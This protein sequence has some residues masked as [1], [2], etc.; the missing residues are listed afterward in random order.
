M[1]RVR[2][3][4]RVRQIVAVAMRYGFQQAVQE[5]ESAQKGL[6][7]RF[8]REEATPDPALA[9]MASGERL[10]RMLEALGPTFI[11]LGQL[12]S[13][14]PDLVPRWAVDELVKLQDRVAPMPLEVVRA[15]LEAELG[16]PPERLFRSF[17]PEPLGTASLGQVHRA[18]LPSGEVVA[19]KV[20]RPGIEKVVQRDLS[21]LAD[22]AE[23][24]EGRLGMTRHIKLTKVVAEL[25]QAL[26]DELVYTIEGR[27]AERMMQIVTPDDRVR[28]PKIYWPLT[29]ARI[30]TTEMF[31][32][33]K[34]TD[35]DQPPPAMRPELARR[36]AR[37]ALKQILIEGFFH[38]DPHA[39][40]LMVFPDG[41]LGVIDWGQVGILT[42][43]MRES[44]DEI[45]IG[46]AT[47]DTERLTEEIVRLG[48][49]DEHSDLEGFRYD[50]NRSLDRYFHLPRTEFPLSSV[51]R[52]ILELSYEHGVHL[53]TEVPML[54]KVLVATEGTCLGLDP[55]FDLR[56]EFA[57]VARQ[58][59]GAQF[60]PE[61]VLKHLVAGGRQLNRFV[62]ALPRQLA[63]ILDR[64]EGGNL[65]VRVERD[66][67]GPTRQ[68]GR[69]INRLSL[70]A[71]GGG[72]M[73]AGALTMDHHPT[74][75]MTVFLSGAVAAVLV[76]IAV[77]RGER[78]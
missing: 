40:N 17:D 34:L 76:V 77:L 24:F 65:T 64:V 26:R 73:V 38:C 51:L 72:V 44:L 41:S 54:I 59:V 20:Q 13:T 33:A 45:F 5:A 78:L 57:P 16:A 32:A 39:G 2:N 11:K 15:Q 10:R 53:P 74:L 28:I 19:V 67:E 66:L 70:A 9:R 8:R 18:V 48:L 55:A 61:Q 36:L 12:L 37:F 49:A 50:L 52:T 58:I 56:A 42:R 62:T 31:E 29:T 68:V 4:A 3:W 69:S 75:G 21:V 30:L 6:L 43:R 27:N 71:V 47:R 25:N 7:R 60:D 14:R 63:N 22:L 1:E 46:I 35:P 23:M